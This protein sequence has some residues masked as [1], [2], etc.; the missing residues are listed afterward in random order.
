MFKCNK[1]RYS[2]H[3]IDS[4]RNQTADSLKTCGYISVIL[5]TDNHLL[6]NDYL[7]P[8]DVITLTKKS[9]DTKPLEFSSLSLED[10]IRKLAPLLKGKDGRDGKDGKD[11][12]DGRDGLRVG[13]CAYLLAG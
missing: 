9:Q 5:S 13:A 3:T 1:C 6:L 10:L 7:S 12:R 2:S 4:T 8:K 11:G